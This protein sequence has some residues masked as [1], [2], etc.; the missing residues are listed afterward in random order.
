MAKMWAGR[1]QKETDAVVNDFNS[2][3]PFDWRMY[4]EDIR[5]SIAH[6]TMLGR[7]GIISAADAEQI[8]AGLRDI[9]SDIEAGKVAFSAE[10]YE[11]IHMANEQMLTERIGD[12]GK[13]LHT[14]R[15]RNDQVA[16][17]MRM[18]VRG[19]IVEIRALVLA[20]LRVLADKAKAHTGTVMPGYTHLQRAQP[21]TFGHHLMATASRASTSA[22]WAA[23]R[24]RARPT[25]STGPSP[26]GRSAS[27]APAITR[28]TACPTATT[29]WSCSPTCPS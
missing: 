19:Q 27:P 6:A 3:V 12:A 25:R 8:A 16:L 22:R 10:L 26:P 28:S 9:L 20:F 29:A 17:D 13:R 1:F 23:A 14:A 11:D 7:Q 18:Y 2:S 21:I 5:G 4:A 24:S 15:S